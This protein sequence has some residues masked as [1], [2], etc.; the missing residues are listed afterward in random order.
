MATDLRDLRPRL[1]IDTGSK[2]SPEKLDELLI[3]GVELFNAETSQI[4]TVTGSLLDRDANPLEKRCITM[5]S[6]LGYLDEQIVNA[7]ENAVVVS[8]VAGRTELANLEWALG[9]R[10]T[11]LRDRIDAVLSR[12]TSF[13][14][15]SEVSC[16]EIGQSLGVVDDC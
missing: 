16:E 2:L 6:L 10:R 7:S 5:F 8:N 9:K 3:H 4:F 15:N 13:G 14:V 1:D 11:E 12:L